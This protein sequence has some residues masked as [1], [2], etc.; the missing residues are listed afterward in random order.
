MT[1]PSTTCRMYRRGGSDVVYGRA[2]SPCGSARLKALFAC[3]ATASWHATSPL[4]AH[5]RRRRRR[6]C[7]LLPRWCGS[8]AICGSCRCARRA[9]GGIRHTSS[10][11]VRLAR[12]ARIELMRRP[13]PRHRVRPRGYCGCRRVV[14]QRVIHRRAELPRHSSHNLSAGGPLKEFA[15]LR[16]GV[17]T[18]VLPVRVRRH[19]ARPPRPGLGTRQR[20]VRAVHPTFARRVAIARPRG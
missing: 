3:R 10:S 12:R 6:R 9:G 7:A 15:L 13:R 4:A 16:H 17:R 19:L 14:V 18:R 2:A 11:V 20:S 8:G 5:W 1:L